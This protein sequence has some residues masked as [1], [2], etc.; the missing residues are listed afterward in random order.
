LFADNPFQTA[1]LYLFEKSFGI[2]A[3]RT[4]VTNRI[5]CVSAQFFQN[6][7]ARLQWQ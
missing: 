4:G 3:D 1:A 6:V 2:A 5:T 7:F